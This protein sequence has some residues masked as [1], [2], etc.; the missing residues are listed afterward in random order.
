[1]CRAIRS[2][3]YTLTLRFFFYFLFFL[4]AHKRCG[5]FFFVFFTFFYKTLVSHVCNKEEKYI[6]IFY[7]IYFYCLA[8]ST[9]PDYESDGD[10]TESV[11]VDAM[12]REEDE[13]M[14]LDQA[15]DVE[16]GSSGAGED[17]PGAAVGAA[18]PL[19]QQ[20][21]PPAAAQPL[22]LPPPAEQLPPPAAQQ[23]PHELPPPAAPQQLQQPPPPPSTDQGQATERVRF[24]ST[25]S[26]GSTG[27]QYFTLPHAY[28]N[29][30]A[31]KLST[32]VVRTLNGCATNTIG[33]VSPT[34]SFG[35]NDCVRPVNLNYRH[36]YKSRMN[37]SSSFNLENFTCNS[38][39]GNAHQILFREGG[40]VPQGYGSVRFHPCGSKLSRLDTNY[41]RGRGV[42]EGLQD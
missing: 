41:P 25:A 30:R 6:S 21:P 14:D 33:T 23:R 5:G 32:K 37:I 12:L 20:Q 16:A 8:M 39:P 28:N 26:T 38:C 27:S 17:V 42:P 1:L 10:A 40:G 22:Q 34:G 2:G 11:D 29:I 15:A 31:A 35:E 24:G 36:C 4:T 19:Q 18:A 13:D 7:N 9:L 3:I